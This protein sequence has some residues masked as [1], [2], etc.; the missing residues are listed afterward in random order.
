MELLTGSTKGSV[1]S[2]ILR[3]LSGKKTHV[4]VGTHALLNREVI[5]SI[6]S[7]ALVIIDEE[8][9]FGVQQRNMVNSLTNVLYTTATP[10]PRSL[11]LTAAT[12][13]FTVSTLATQLP[14]KRKVNTVLYDYSKL[15][16]VVSLIRDNLPY[17]TKIFWVTP[18]LNPSESFPGSSAMER[19][20]QLQELF[21]NKVGLL[22]G[23]MSSADKDKV[24]SQFSSTA[25]DGGEGEVE[26]ATGAGINILV[27]TTVIEV[28]IDI[29]DAS[30][31]IIERANYFGLSQIHQIRGRIGRGIRPKDE[32][33]DECLCIL[34]A[35]EAVDDEVSPSGQRLNVLTE[36]NDCFRIAEYD[37]QLRGPGDL[38]GYRQHGDANYRVALMPDHT[39]LLALA[40]ETALNIWSGNYRLPPANG[41]EVLTVNHPYIKLLKS[42]YLQPSNDT[43]NTDIVADTDIS[44]IQSMHIPAV[45]DS[46]M[47]DLDRLIIASHT[48][49]TA[50]TTASTSA[51]TAAKTTKA[52]KASTKVKE[53]TDSFATN[54]S[55][56]IAPSVLDPTPLAPPMRPVVMLDI[57]TET[58]LQSTFRLIPD[59]AHATPYLE[60]VVVILDVETTGLSVYD[61]EIIQLSAKILDSPTSDC[62]TGSVLYEGQCNSDR[63]SLFNAYIKPENKTVSGF[64]AGLTG[65][66]QYSIP[67]T[68]IKPYTYILTLYSTIYIFIY[69]C[70]H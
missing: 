54:M 68:C 1:R 22:H 9:R 53:I 18:S 44:E 52:T 36:T 2:G 32:K 25:S 30:I 34:L 29:P 15:G 59:P 42:F 20:Q 67:Y 21:P 58:K 60:P 69:T 19:H 10:I 49:P 62:T 4:L 8:Q 11:M 3:N 66:E 70:L 51:V 27:S 47:S 33:L 65:K 50:A 61:D 55:V 45:E 24:I 13:T 56:A 5:D 14:V 46:D 48:A 37:L 16:D 26:G 40:R 64:I 43:D 39:S 38:F 41:G 6:P 28:G 63:Q 35:P 7:L 31:C 17:G 12:E 23:R 57:M